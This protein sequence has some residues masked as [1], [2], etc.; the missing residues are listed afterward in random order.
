MLNKIKQPAHKRSIRDIPIPKGRSEHGNA[1]ASSVD[2]RVN[3]IKNTQKTERSTR[4]RKPKKKNKRIY[5]WG[6]IV[7]SLF[8]L[9]LVLANIFS[10][11]TINIVPRNYEIVNADINIDLIAL[12]NLDTEFQLGYRSVDFSNTSEITVPANGQEL[13]Q[14]KASGIITVFNTFNSSPQRLIRNTRFESSEGLIYRTPV[15]VEIPGFVETGGEIIPGS[16]DIEVFADEIGQEYNTSGEIT[17]VIPGFIGQEAFDFFSART[18]TNLTGGYDGVKRIIQDSDL[19]NAKSQL[20]NNLKEQLRNEINSQIPNNVVALYSDE[21]LEFGSIEQIDAGDSEATLKMS[22][23]VSVLLID[24]GDLASAISGQQ[25]DTGYRSGDQVVIKNL[26]ELTL[27]LIE[28]GSNKLIKVSG[29]IKIQWQNDSVLL[30]GELTGKNKDEFRN[31]IS[32]YRGVT[33]V[34]TKFSPFWKNNF[35]NNP[36]RINVREVNEN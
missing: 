23:K 27:T 7:T 3:E 31:I 22:G 35:P 32:N 16:I 12:D 29:D 21:S 25:P 11:A 30:A 4:V 18:K 28:D 33:S 6:S 24:K 5:F 2:L 20:N 1:T 26:D 17:F 14:E 13:V 34:T 15:S 19:E 9:I 36:D 10:T 8:I